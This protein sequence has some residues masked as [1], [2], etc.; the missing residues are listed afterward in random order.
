MEHMHKKFEINQTKIKGGCQSGRK[1]VPDDHKSD[2]PLVY[3][4]SAAFMSFEH[5]SSVRSG[6]L[7]QSQYLSEIKVINL[8]IHV[9]I[10]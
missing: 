8:I 4:L 1:V 5:Q 7:D 2:L 9:K 6:V 3:T 10:V